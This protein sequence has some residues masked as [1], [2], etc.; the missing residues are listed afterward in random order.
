[1]CLNIITLPKFIALTFTRAK[2]AVFE[3][4]IKH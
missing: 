4:S 3:I 1:M 2:A